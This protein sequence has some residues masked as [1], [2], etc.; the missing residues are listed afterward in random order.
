MVGWGEGWI[1]V[2]EKRSRVELVYNSDVAVEEQG[3]ERTVVRSSVTADDEVRNVNRLAK[4]IVP[5]RRASSQSD[6]H[7]KGGERVPGDCRYQ[8][9]AARLR[10][11]L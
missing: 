10:P 1:V 4:T 7:G 8:F 6:D 2:I 9:S 11:S 5:F 3:E